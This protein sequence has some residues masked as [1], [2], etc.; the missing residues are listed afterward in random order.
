M[1]SAYDAAK[2]VD[3]NCPVGI[4]AKSV[5]VNYLE[6]T[7]KAR[8]KDHFDFITLHP[9]EVLNGIADNNGSEAVYMSI[10]PT[11]RKMLAAQTVS[12]TMGEKTIEKGLHTNS[13][14]G[15]SAADNVNRGSVATQRGQKADR[16]TVEF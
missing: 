15:R 7:I 1:V 13:D 10:V 16:S 2:A 3:P 8:A 14:T 11:V 9:Y 6:Q 12:I 4:A 5:H